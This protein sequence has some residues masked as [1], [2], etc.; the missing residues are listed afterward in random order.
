MIKVKITNGISYEDDNFVCEFQLSNRHDYSDLCIIKDKIK[1]KE[2]GC[3]YYK[4][5]SLNLWLNQY[6]FELEDE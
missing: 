5:E 2:Y 4:K 3:S 6:G 1:K